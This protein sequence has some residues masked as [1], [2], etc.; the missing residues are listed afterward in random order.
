MHK[1]IEKVRKGGRS[2]RDDV[3][4][5]FEGGVKAI[6]TDDEGGGKNWRFLHDVICERPLI[7]SIILYG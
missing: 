7:V 1:R 4:F 3:I 5:C 2:G 6:M